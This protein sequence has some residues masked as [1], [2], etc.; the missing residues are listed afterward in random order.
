VTTTFAAAAL[1]AA[2]AAPD[3]TV[4]DFDEYLKGPG[5]WL[6]DQAGSSST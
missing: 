5:A 6:M 1:A 2:G 4:A 3:V